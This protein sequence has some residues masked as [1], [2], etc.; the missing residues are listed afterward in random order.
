MLKEMN[1]REFL[2]S[3]AIAGTVLISGD[4]LKGQSTAA[5]GS[6]KIPEA[7][8][9]TVTIITDNYYDALRPDYKIAKR[10]NIKPGAPIE[11]INLHAEH[12]LAY[13]VETEMNGRTHSFLFD[14]GIDSQSISR[15]MEL[16]NIDF[17]TLEALGLSHGHFDHWGALVALL[18]SQRENIRK[19]IPLHVGEETF[20]ERFIKTPAGLVSLGQL[21]KEN[22][23]G[24][25]IKVIENKN[26]AQI[27]PGAYLTGKIE[28]TTDYEKGSPF[29][30]IKRGDKAE[31]DN[32]MGEQAVVLNAKGKGLVVLSGCA[33]TGIVNA[34][35]HA[36]KITG[37]DK[38]YAVMGGFHLTGAK[39]E[40]IQK[41]VADIK[42]AAPEYIV[43]TH[44]TGFEAIALFA[45][46][47]PK[48]FILNTA[49][50]KYVIAA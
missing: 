49:G 15:N 45:K 26:P 37:I 27:V 42:T 14:Y 41:T 33:H 32:F 3:S 13:H 30:L 17:K 21:K 43:P 22:I 25:G 36:Q 47:M 4:L 6:I 2:K 1:R 18:I 28:R 16:L 11:N 38:V 8:K 40:I 24:L 9:I 19:G 46:E 34:V 50:T 23:E 39:P 5:H 20:V 29:L 48:Q 12:G 7:E 35:K 44:C 10:Y 31:Q